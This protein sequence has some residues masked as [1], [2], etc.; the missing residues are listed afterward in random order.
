[1]GG[2]QIAPSIVLAACVC[3]RLASDRLLAALAKRFV[4]TPDY[5]NGFLRHGPRSIA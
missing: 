2:S 3:L 1:M 4:A 5:L